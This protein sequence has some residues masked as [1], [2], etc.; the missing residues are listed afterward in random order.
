MQIPELSTDIIFVIATIII[1]VVGVIYWF[2]FEKP[3]MRAREALKGLYYEPAKFRKATVS[4]TF[5]YYDEKISKGVLAF[6]IPVAVSVVIP[7][8]TIPA[9]Y[10]FIIT[11]SGIF[12]SFFMVMFYKKVLDDA[13]KSRNINKP[14]GT[15]ISYYPETGDNNELWRRME[16]D[17]EVMVDD[18]QKETIV[19]QLL[20][21]AKTLPSYNSYLKQKMKDDKKEGD[22]EDDDDED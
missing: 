16:N 4:Q 2:K 14:F 19:D 17:G 13:E 7:V 9:P 12:V 11:L 15:A 3:T 10:N 21:T 1:S 8:L 20:D 22:D 18:T 5:K 6:C